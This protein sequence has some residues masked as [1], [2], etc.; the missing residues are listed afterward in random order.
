MSKEN[1]M[2]EIKIEKV[3]LNMGVGEPGEK[4]EKLWELA[5][6]EGLNY[7][8]LGNVPGTEKENTYCPGCGNL[9]IERRG[10]YSE[11]L[12]LDKMMGLGSLVRCVGRL[13]PYP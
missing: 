7:V 10:F 9:L 5:K 12:G 11:V 6:E 1:P 4:L 13:L 3:T 8:Y 2:R